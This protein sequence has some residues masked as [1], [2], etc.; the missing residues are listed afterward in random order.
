MRV[1]PARMGRFRAG[2]VVTAAALCAGC[3]IPGGPGMECTAAGA[4]DGISVTVA[5]GLTLSRPSLEVCD[6]DACRTYELQ[7]DPGTKSVDLGCDS[8]EPVGSCSASASPDGTMMGFVPTEEL[9]GQPVEVT[10]MS[11][12]EQYAVT[13]TPES[14]YPNGPNCPGEALQLLVTLDEGGLTVRSS[15]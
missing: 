5:K 13:G 2:M 8:D 14:V 12:E 4:S 7:L 10:L 11:A 9:S 1:Y 15:G 6:D 3:G